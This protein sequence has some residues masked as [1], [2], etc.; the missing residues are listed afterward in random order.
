MVADVGDEEYEE[1]DLISPGA[2]YGWP[3]TEGPDGT[4]GTAPILWYRHGDNCGAVIG[5]QFSRG[6]ALGP[7]YEGWYV[8]GDFACGRVWAVQ[9]VDGAVVATRQI[10]EEE[11]NYTNLTFGPDGALYLSGTAGVINRLTRA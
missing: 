9:E 3:D 1:I 6:S 10:A 11:I 7:D 8:F 5:G 2:D 4:T